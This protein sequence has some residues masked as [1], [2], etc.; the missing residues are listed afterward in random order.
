MKVIIIGVKKNQ[1]CLMREVHLTVLRLTNLWALNPRS[2]LNLE[3][4]VFVEGGKPE[5][6]AK[7]PQSMDENQQQ[8]QP[9]YDAGSRIRTQATLVGGMCSHHCAIPAPLECI[10][11]ASSSETQ[12]QLVGAE[13]KNQQRKVEEYNFFP[14]PPPPGSRWM[15]LRELPT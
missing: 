11:A 12:R 10:G 14:S 5:Y 3:V 8:T 9:T 13:G 6:P 15:D 7:N 1:L 4:L 2:N